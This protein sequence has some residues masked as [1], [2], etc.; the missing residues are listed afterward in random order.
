MTLVEQSNTSFYLQALPATL[1]NKVFL[2][3]VVTEY[4]PSLTEI[5][6]LCLEIGDSQQLVTARTDMAGSM[7][8]RLPD[9][10]DYKQS[11]FTYVNRIAE[12]GNDLLQPSPNVLKCSELVE[13]EFDTLAALVKTLTF[14]KDQSPHVWVPTARTVQN[15]VNLYSSFYNNQR[16]DLHKCAWIAAQSMGQLISRVVVS[17]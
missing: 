2:E 8:Y 6:R 17:E 14:D 15:T 7:T 16:P 12:E 4:N 5:E 13:Q 10:P 11:Q 1:V 3:E 9:A